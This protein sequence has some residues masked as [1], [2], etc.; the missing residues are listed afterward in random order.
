M[1]NFA[2]R[3]ILASFAAVV[4]IAQHAPASA[5]DT[6]VAVAANFTEPAREI[7]AAFAS[8]TGHNAMLNFG[9]SGAFYTQMAHGA[10][11]E[12][13][14]SADSERPAKAEK[15]GIGVP[16]T[17]FT[18]AIGQL[19]LYSTKP[20]LVDNKGAVL[21]SGNF[22]KI[23]IA[24]PIAAPYGVAAEETMKKLGVDAALA[25]KIVKGTSITQA[26]QFVATGAAELGFVALSQ[27]IGE[28]GGS[29][30]V[31]PAN[32]HTPIDQQAIL[33]KTGDKNPA[34]RAF[35]KFLKSGKAK[36]IITRYGYQV[37]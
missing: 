25:P 18:Y 27:V 37:R 7:A 31:V 14:L 24:D 6:Q 1:L 22:E 12:V 20:G 8:A 26:Y 21:K 30:W 11:F 13:F 23:S 35:L 10:P 9:S 17:R 28:T 16:G 29:R 15:E 32:L 34:A 2:P 33:L 4:A 3:H 36:A 19:V 5:A